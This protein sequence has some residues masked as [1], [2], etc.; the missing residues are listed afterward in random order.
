M[1]GISVSCPLRDSERATQQEVKR[2]ESDR[3]PWEGWPPQES[4]REGTGKS[5]VFLVFCPF[6][7]TNTQE[8]SLVQP[9]KAELEKR[10]R[11]S[12]EVWRVG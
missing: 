11:D 5:Q 8:M 6:R 4:T 2:D 1:D 10:L 12:I 7:V 9:G 3:A